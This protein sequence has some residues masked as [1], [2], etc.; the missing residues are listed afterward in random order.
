[1]ANITSDRLISKIQ[2]VDFAFKNTPVVKIDI[3]F[4]G[5][6]ISVYGKYEAKGFSGSCK[7]RMARFLISDGI[8]NGDLHEGDTVID[9]TSGNAG[10]AIASLCSLIGINVKVFIP[11]WVSRERF[12]ALSLRNAEFV[13]ISNDEGGFIECRKRVF[14]LSKK[15]GYYSVNQF[16]NPRNAIAHKETT[17][18]E[19]FST[20][21]LIGVSP[22][23]FVAGY[24]TGGTVMGACLLVNESKLP[25]SVHP[26]EPKQ[27]PLISTGIEIKKPEMLHKLDGI[28]DDFVPEIIDMNKLDTPVVIDEDDAIYLARMINNIGLSFGI[29]SG[30]NLLGCIKQA[31]E[32]GKSVAATVFCDDSSKYY[33]SDLYKPLEAKEGFLSNDIKVVDITFIK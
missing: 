16:G 25:C 27:M 17:M 14:A 3:I 28:V 15:E 26:L 12:A 22:E 19:L 9:T 8:K 5:R 11:D 21:D 18:T 23:V 2:Q 32:S 29:S 24:G 4:R 13:K 1:M 20:L 31:Y 7:D 33:S 30:A 10:I 6:L